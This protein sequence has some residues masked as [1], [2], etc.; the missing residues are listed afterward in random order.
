[1]HTEPIKSNV[2]SDKCRLDLLVY[3]FNRSFG[4]RAALV[5]QPMPKQALDSNIFL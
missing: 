4:A 1:M 5:F 2:K 3:V